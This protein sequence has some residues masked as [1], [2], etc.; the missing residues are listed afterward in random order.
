MLK[1][2]D[3]TLLV[4]I[5]FLMFHVSANAT[6]D[7]SPF[8]HSHSVFTALLKS[9]VDSGK[10]D[11]KG[12]IKSR[13]Q[14]NNYLQS[15]GIVTEKQYNSWTEEQKLAFWIN[16]YN[17]FTI[18]AIIDNYPIKRSFTLV[19]IFYAPENSILQIPG[20]WK[21]LKFQAAGRDVT[22]DHI[23]HG[24]LRVDFNE[25]RIHAAIN[26]A[27]I[28]CPDLMNEAYTADRLSAQL[29]LASINFVNNSY[30]GVQ[31]APD[32]KSVKVSKIFKWFGE[33]FYENY[34][35]EIFSERKKR[36]NGVLG[37]IITYTQ[38]EE[39]KKVIESNDFKLKHL[40]YDWTLNEK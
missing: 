13:D 25:P 15:L 18:Q 36:D 37:F 3:F 17:A 1:N 23:E 24:I 29:D 11:Y 9:N 5:I 40:H 20:V 28:G 8:D 21:K 35:N 7:K 10:V 27:S 33:D 6:N 34:N 38:D 4:F 32:G 2:L 31:I 22:L 39:A 12:F 16:A 26:C 19:G 14:F 30:K